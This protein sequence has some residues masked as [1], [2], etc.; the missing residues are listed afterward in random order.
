MGYRERKGN[1]REQKEPKRKKCAAVNKAEKSWRS[2]EH[3]GIRLVDA[4]V[5]DCAAGFW[6]SF[7]LVFSY[8]VPFPSSWNGNV[9]V[10]PVPLCIRRIWFFYFVFIGNCS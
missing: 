10:Y 7:G 6:P 5:R 8:Y 2:K 4:E 1:N 3:F 9:C